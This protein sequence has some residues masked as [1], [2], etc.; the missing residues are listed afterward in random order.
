M[1]SAVPHD[2]LPGPRQDS[3]SHSM[4]SRIVS[5]SGRVRNPSSV[6]AFRLEKSLFLQIPDV[7]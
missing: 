1:Q 6:A 4:V 7:H 3:L 5:R 2:L